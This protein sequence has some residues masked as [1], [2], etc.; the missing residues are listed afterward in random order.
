M[1]YVCGDRS[2]C[3]V[4][5][6]PCPVRS[7][8]GVCGHRTALC[9][10]RSACAIT[11]PPCAV[12]NPRVRSPNRP[13]RSPNRPVRSP[14]RVCG[15]RTAL[16]GHRSACAVT[17]PPCAVTDPRVRSPNRPVR[18]PIR[19]CGHRTALC[20]HRSACAVTEPP[21]AVIISLWTRLVCICRYKLTA[22]VPAPCLPCERGTQ[23]RTGCF[24]SV[25]GWGGGECCYTSTFDIGLV[26]I[27]YN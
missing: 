17:E 3:A 4:T 20:G 14:I 22:A 27:G 16:C 15:H 6:P 9:G 24:I 21:S 26:S 19:V 2:A 23:V 1:V 12:T 11:E 5:E 10:H 8:I 7:P 18:S 25:L 13:V